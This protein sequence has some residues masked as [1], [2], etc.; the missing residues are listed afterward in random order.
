MK[1]SAFQWAAASSLLLLTLSAF[2]ATRPHYGGVLHI[3]V[4][5]APPSLDPADITQ[6]DSFT[7]RNLTYLVFETLVT[8]D[9]LGG[10]RP[11]LATS[12]VQNIS[13][14]PQSWQFRL[15]PHVTFHDGTALNPA[16]VAD[17]LRRVNPSW[18][19]ISDVNSVIVECD[20]ACPKLPEEL[21]LSRNA[22][23]DKSADGKLSGTG[24][25]HIADWQPE[26]KLIVAAEERYWAGRPFIDGIE[27]EFGKNS[28]EQLTALELGKSDLIEI[29]AEQSRR[30]SSSSMQ[31]WRSQPLELIALLFAHSAPTPEEKSLREALALCVERTSMTSVIL[32]GAGDPAASILPNWMSGYG[33]VFSTE[34]DLFRAQHL[35]EAVRNPAAWT[36]SYDSADAT[37]SLLAERVALNARDAGLQL[38][39][40]RSAT[41]DIRLERIPLPSDPVLA[42]SMIAST[43][44]LTAP[45]INRD[46]AE[47]LFSAEK[48]LLAS[49]T[50]IPLFHLPVVYVATSAL[51]DWT[52]QPD[53]TWNLADAWVAREPSGS[54]HP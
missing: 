3:S 5:E 19:I 20:V 35:R 44:G 18:K 39:P 40:T 46:S 7:R 29:S 1:L 21:T 27:I 6:P 43:V 9:E 14:R 4:S 10:I 25:F 2:A 22:I 31:I 30:I 8:H 51:R 50:L 28:R 52:P 13:G 36:L 41:A 32:Q 17:S 37:A 26:K 45:T 49:Q 24:P 12:W 54:G 33:F 11:G 53:G 48:E 42:L 34:A 47:D 38:Q 16:I 23:V 15:R